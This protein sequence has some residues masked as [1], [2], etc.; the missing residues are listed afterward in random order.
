M[1]ILKI[2][3]YA[4]VCLLLFASAFAEDELRI[5]GLDDYMLEGSR[6]TLSAEIGDKPAVVKWFV[7]DKKLATITGAG[8]LSVKTARIDRN[9]EVTATSDDGQT[10]TRTFRIVPKAESMR[11]YNG[12]EMCSGKQI[13]VCIDDANAALRF[14]CRVKPA[15]A[16]DG[17]K[18][19]SSDESVAEVD[20]EGRVTLVSSGKAVI[21]AK[22]LSGRYTACDILVYHNINSIDIT[23]P[24]YIAVG[25]KIKATVST[26][27]PT[28]ENDPLEWKTSNARRATVDDSGVITGVRAG[29]TLVSCESRSGAK[30]EIEIEVYA[31][32]KTI[33]TDKYERIISL[34]TSEKIG[35]RISPVDAVFPNLT[36]E[37]DDP[38]IAAVSQDGTVSGVSIGTTVLRAKAMGGTSCEV[39]LHVENMPLKSVTF[40]DRYITLTA[41][42][43]RY[44]SVVLAPENASAREFTLEI[45]D[46]SIAY[47]DEDVRI[48]SRNAGTTTVSARPLGAENTTDTAVLRVISEDDKPLEG[49]KIGLNP[50]HQLYIDLTQLPIAP[51]SRNTKNAN[52]GGT[53]GVVTMI[54]EY[55]ANLQISFKLRDVLEDMG[56]E[57]VMTR[58]ENDVYLTNVDRAQMLNEANVDVALQIH[59]NANKSSD[60]HGA[61]VYSK[62]DDT[63][64]QRI[65]RF[66][67]DVM[68]E[69]TGAWN[70][71]LKLSNAYMSLNWSE[72]P[73]V[74][75]ECGFMTNPTEDIQ[76]ANPEYQQKIAV[77]IAKGL[78][79]YYGFSGD[80]A[81]VADCW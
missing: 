69:E 25:E 43:S 57:V 66:I 60:K 64:S 35:F 31:P 61:S 79:R 13:T 15:E 50:G 2:F 12:S 81:S 17:V 27:P 44:P 72:T 7:S 49:L 71:G 29:K 4:T 73:S 41:S 77:G 5:I 23:E 53:H 24:L 80:F 37:T 62:I 65:A 52:S 55:E 54:E 63:L 11:M 1:K 6:A 16:A 75:I 56:A 51:G 39:V 18:W 47:V 9:V 21:T 76:L 26:D 45:A 30:A 48:I 14:E 68:C 22:A 46:E 36:F 78:A 3:L 32:V 74:L 40:V 20:A 67:I 42:E 38:S 10:V 59:N 19:L 33:R 34:N 70:R 58:E 8:V 28:A